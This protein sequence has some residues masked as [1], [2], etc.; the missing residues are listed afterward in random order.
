MNNIYKKTIINLNYAKKQRESILSNKELNNNINS[1][2]E[3]FSVPMRL[4]IDFH[5]DLAKIAINL[6]EDLNNKYIREILLSS[7]TNILNRMG[8]I[9]IFLDIDLISEV[10]E[11]KVKDLEIILNLLFN[12]V[13]MLDDKK[14]NSRVTMI[15]NII[16][17]F[18]ELVYSSGLTLKDLREYYDKQHN[19]NISELKKEMKR[20]LDQFNSDEIIRAANILIDEVIEKQQYEDFKKIIGVNI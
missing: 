7:L 19:N 16:P 11:I 13:S 18:A 12:N 1:Q 17:L 15:N 5:T 14:A 4:I 10:K 8:D 20:L 6:D 2:L 3:I 9:A